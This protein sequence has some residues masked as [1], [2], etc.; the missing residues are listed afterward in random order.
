MLTWSSSTVL[1]LLVSG[2][3]E[4]PLLGFSCLCREFHLFI[5]QVECRGGRLGLAVQ[6]RVHDRYGESGF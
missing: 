5:S 4:M 3:T 1:D 6:K 2:S